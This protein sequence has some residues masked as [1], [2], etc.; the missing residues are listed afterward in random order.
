M[1][2]FLELTGKI[3][4]R[5]T[6]NLKATFSGNFS[7]R[8]SRQYINQYAKN[9]S[10]HYPKIAEDVYGGSLKLSQVFDETSFL[11]VIL[12]YRDQKYQRAD[13]FWNDDIL[14]YGDSLKNAQVGVFLENGDGNNLR[15]DDNG[16]YWEKGRVWD[17][18]QQYRMQT[19]GADLN[20]TKQFK[21]HL[22]E[23]GGSFEQNIVRYYWL[24]PATQVAVK[25]NSEQRLTLYNGRKIFIEVSVMY[26]GYDL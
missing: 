5:I 19:M 9:N 2:I 21:N 17:A 3:N 12:R 16:V 4:S 10:E 7:I 6:D 11:D 20:F 26:Y 25:I 23:I 22:I 13:G 24:S 18:F 15:A 1:V 14:A 8:N